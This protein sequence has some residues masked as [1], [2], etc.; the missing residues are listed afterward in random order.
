MIGP[1]EVKEFDMG[2]EL[3]LKESATSGTA[4]EI[5]AD[6][7]VRVDVHPG[8]LPVIVRPRD[9]RLAESTD[10]FVEWF[11]A[12][13]ELFDHVAAEHGALLFRGMALKQTDDFQRAIS[14]YPA[15]GLTYAGGGAPRDQLA[16]RVFEATKA[17]KEY[18]LILHQEMAYLKNFPRMIAFFCQ[19][20]PAAGGETT[21]AD[22]RMLKD[23]LPRR[24][25]DKVESKGVCYLRNFRD[26]NLP[27][28]PL[29]ALMHK[30]WTAGFNTEDPAEAEATARAMGLEAEWM[31]DGSLQTSLVLSGFTDHPL[32][33]V[34]HWFNHIGSQNQNRKVL[35]PERWDAVHES[36]YMYNTVVYGDGSPIDPEDLQ[37]VYDTFDALTIAIPW[38][39]GDMTLIDNVVTAHGR[40]PFEG[41]RDVQVAL[42]G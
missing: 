22:F 12:R 25:W 37:A 5:A 13:K 8:G 36:K 7:R 6:G 10:A 29:H 14:H 18:F 41:E 20:A 9:S 34:R 31:D 3:S 33:G 42:L 26:P 4:E 35:G 1:A 15:N 32:T 40:H 2:V 11:A 17:R 16:E 39:D 19:K 27:T 28:G 38:H 23:R 30:T 24:L 21:L